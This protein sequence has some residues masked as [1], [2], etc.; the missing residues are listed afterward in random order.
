MLIR[1]V[2]Y[3]NIKNI[4]CWRGM[5]IRKVKKFFIKTKEMVVN[6]L[7]DLKLHLSFLRENNIAQAVD[8]FECGALDECKNRLK[9]TLRLWPNDEQVKY[10]LALVYLIDRDLTKAYK[11]LITI[12]NY[13]QLR[14]AKMISMA[15]KGLTLKIIN[16]YV[17]TLNLYKVEN[18]IDKM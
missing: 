11:L 12:K 2:G 17:E 8:F 14:I 18:E 3:G 1:Y 4:L 15:E 16:V 9:I 10:L 5:Y 13:N 6:N 7:N